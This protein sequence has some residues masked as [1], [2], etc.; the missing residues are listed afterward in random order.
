MIVNS[1]ILTIMLL[2][3]I[4]LSAMLLSA[5]LLCCYYLDIGVIEFEK[6]FQRCRDFIRSSM[7]ADSNIGVE[8][9]YDLRLRL[10]I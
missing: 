4:L 3:T 2:S 8:G 7:V 9:A 6:R 10:G 1:N 5:M